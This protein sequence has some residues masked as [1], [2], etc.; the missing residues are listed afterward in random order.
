M[1]MESSTPKIKGSKDSTDR[2][3]EKKMRRR[4]LGILLFLA[5]L[6]LYIGLPFSGKVIDANSGEPLPDVIVVAKWKFNSRVSVHNSG[7]SYFFRES[8]TNTQGEY[9]FPFWYWLTL[10]SLSTSSPMV[11][12]YKD[13][14]KP[15]YR[16]S[17]SRG[18][19]VMFVTPTLDD[20]DVTLSPFNGTVSERVELIRTID[21]FLGYKKCLFV[22]T[23][24]I[25]RALEAEE[26]KFVESENY[27]YHPGWSREIAWIE[28]N[29]KF[30]KGFWKRNFEY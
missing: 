30:I 5:I 12:F 10:N 2:D 3:I 26:A 17:S 19:L 16:S 4:V 23:P 15:G 13:G 11:T 1:N 8:I 29:C 25:I 7:N 18:N 20:K 9:K 14:Y 28:D 27:S 21:F 6:F 24:Q 22:D